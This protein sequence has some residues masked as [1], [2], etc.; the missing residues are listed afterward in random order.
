MKSVGVQGEWEVTTVKE[1]EVKL[2][3]ISKGGRTFVHLTR[4]A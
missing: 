3:N 1:G 4:R 2:T